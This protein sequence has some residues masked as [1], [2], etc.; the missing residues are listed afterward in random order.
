MHDKTTKHTM[1]NDHACQVQHV[2][3]GLTYVS[4][5]NAL[6]CTTSTCPHGPARTPGSFTHVPVWRVHLT[7]CL[8]CLPSAALPLLSCTQGVGVA[9]VVAGP[10][11]W[12][13]MHG[14]GGAGGVGAGVCCCAGCAHT[15]GLQEEHHCTA[16]PHCLS[17][18][19]W[20]LEG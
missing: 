16:G 4:C 14:Q 15:G 18:S 6:T 1:H 10:P 2:H 9:A 3:S 8:C 11:V 7:V 13:H 5:S 20:L 12:Y 17:C 19:A